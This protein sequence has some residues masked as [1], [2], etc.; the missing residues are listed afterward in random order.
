M[1]AIYVPLKTGNQIFGR[2]SDLL[3]TWP[4]RRERLI[5]INS[6]SLKFINCVE[7]ELFTF[8]QVLA[9]RFDIFIL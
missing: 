7:A 4:V 9:E 8:K 3:K 1:N 5:T 6:Q 2:I